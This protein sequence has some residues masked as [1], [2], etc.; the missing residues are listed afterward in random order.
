MSTLYISLA[1]FDSFCLM[2]SILLSQFLP[3]YNI[4]FQQKSNFLCKTLRL[5][6][7]IALQIP[8]WIMVLITLDRYLNVC[9]PSKLKFIKNRKRLIGLIG[10]IIILSPNSLIYY[11][12]NNEKSNTLSRI[13]N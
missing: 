9:Y 5:W 11:N 12:S 4:L 6:Q 1:I 13:Q 2:N 7:R 10:L 3:S 8:S